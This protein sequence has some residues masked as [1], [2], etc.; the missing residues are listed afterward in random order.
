LQRFGEVRVVAQVLH[1]VDQRE[2]EPGQVAAVEHLA[3]HHL[4][5]AGIHCARR[6]HFMQFPDRQ[7]GLGRCRKR[8]RGGR[9][10]RLPDE[11]VD[12]LEDDA[13]TRRPRVDDVLAEGGEHGLQFREGRVVSADH[14]VELAKLRFDGSTGERC[15]DEAHA[16]FRQ[17]FA[18]L[19]GCRRFARRRV[20]HHE[21]LVRHGRNAVLAVDDFLDLRRAGHAQDDDVGVARNIGIGLDF[22]GARCQKISEGCAVAIDPHRQRK[23]LGDEILGDA[24]AHEA[25]ADEAD[26]GL[27]H[28]LTPRCVDSSRR[29]SARAPK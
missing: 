17:R 14:D 26:A 25:D 9:G 18:H 16:L 22:R 3:D 8:F 13:V 11:I 1:R 23:A 28:L 12:E 19:R 5:Q 24:V 15:V 10:D 20:D 29:P 27:V 7:A 6:Y 4:E 21:T 2:L